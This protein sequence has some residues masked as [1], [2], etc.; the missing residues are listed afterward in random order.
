[1]EQQSPSE[2]NSA[3]AAKY[4]AP[5]FSAFFAAGDLHRNIYL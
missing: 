3:W 5:R 2:G 4:S 1:M